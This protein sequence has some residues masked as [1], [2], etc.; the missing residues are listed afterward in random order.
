MGSHVWANILNIRAEGMSTVIICALV[1]TEALHW[2]GTC[3]SNQRGS[4]FMWGSHQRVPPGRTLYESF[5]S[6]QL[7][8]QITLVLSG[9]ILK[10]VE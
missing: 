3:A 9:M 6:T 7:S 10:N 2:T 4:T 5:F 8:K 1:T